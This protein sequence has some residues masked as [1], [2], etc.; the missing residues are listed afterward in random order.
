MTT[1]IAILGDRDPSNGNHVAT[2]EAL[3][4]S[5]RALDLT[6]E[7]AWWSTD[8]LLDA[9]ALAEVARA[10]G[11]FC[12]T[13]SPYRSLEGALRGIELAR[14][15]E[16]PFLGTCGGFQHAV[17]EYARNVAGLGTA[18]HAEYYGASL[19]DAVISPLTCSL[20][21]QWFDVAF[22]PGSRAAACYA[23]T[24]AREQ[25][26]CSYGINPRWLGTLLQRGLS[27]V[28]RAD[29]GSPRVMELPAHPFFLA[30]LFV[31]QAR[32]TQDAPHPLV[33]GFVRAAARR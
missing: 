10:D 12:T 30:T 29:D 3:Q 17:I 19:E 11:I 23:G 21:G 22:E 33:T 18:A 9:A 1:R 2:D 27:I 6:L 26:Y 16:R 15:R 28:G 14:V 8:A 25:Y 32:S 4:H 31:P 5:A 24:R 7:S 13:G 20:L